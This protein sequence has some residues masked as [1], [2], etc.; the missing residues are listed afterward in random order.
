MKLP[1]GH[2]VKTTVKYTLKMN[3]LE[4]FIKETLD[5]VDSFTGYVRILVDKGEYEEEI[6]AILSEGELL[7]G[8]RKLLSS[9]T[10]FY[11]NEC[12]FGNPFEFHRCGISVVSLTLDDIDMIKV[13]HPDCIILKDI[14]VEE[15]EVRNERDELLKKYRIKEMSDSEITN[16]LEKLNGD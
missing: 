3:S 2:I 5:D 10:I 8:E 9:G 6:K 11:G 16:L 13:S 1:K 15:Q 7:G 14:K 12:R 4:E